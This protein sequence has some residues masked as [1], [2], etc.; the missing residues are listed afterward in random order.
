MKSLFP[1]AKALKHVVEKYGAIEGGKQHLTRLSEFLPTL[2][3]SKTSSATTASGAA[4]ANGPSSSAANPFSITRV[5]RAPRELVVKAWTERDQLAKWFGPKGSQVI[6][7]KLD[8]RVGGT[9]HYGLKSSDGSVMW[10]RWKFEELALPGRMVFVSSFSDPKGGLARAP[11]FDGK[12]PLETHSVVTFSEHAGIGK[13]TV[14][15]LEWVPLRATAEELALFASMHDSM[16]GGWGG[17][18]DQLDEHLQAT[19]AARR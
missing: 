2:S 4:S 8:L 1:S 11:F 15:K 18:F 7:A 10:G 14:V 17:T 19:A 12:W 16:R 9:F 13:G 6:D 5:F 3:A